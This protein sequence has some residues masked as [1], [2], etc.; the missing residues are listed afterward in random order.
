MCKSNISSGK[1]PLEG[2]KTKDEGQG[3]SV[4]GLLGNNRR[5]NKVIRVNNKIG[6]TTLSLVPDVWLFVVVAKEACCLE[7]VKLKAIHTCA[8]INLERISKMGVIYNP[9]QICWFSKI[10]LHNQKAISERINVDKR[11][12]TMRRKRSKLEESVILNNNR[13]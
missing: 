7:V 6:D 9:G 3:H 2:D 1:R 12:R 13:K 11:V 5:M 4:V 10:I 8:E